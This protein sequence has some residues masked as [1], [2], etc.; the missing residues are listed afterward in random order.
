MFS[1]EE[2]LESDSCSLTSWIVM[3][4]LLMTGLVMQVY[5]SLAKTV[6]K[7]HSSV[8]TFVPK[9]KGCQILIRYGFL[10]HYFKL[11]LV[12]RKMTLLI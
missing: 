11:S 1:D 10:R 12:L 6:T 4:L 2:S 8:S 5:P 9:I 3:D 7:L